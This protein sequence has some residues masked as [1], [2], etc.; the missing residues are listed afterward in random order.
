MD[1]ISKSLEDEDRRALGPIRQV[2][3]IELFAGE[4]DSFQTIDSI[5]EPLESFEV[6]LRVPTAYWRVRGEYS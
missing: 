2:L 5:I 6:P 1:D 4:I 3:V